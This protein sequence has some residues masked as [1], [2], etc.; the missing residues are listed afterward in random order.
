MK[1]R[2]VGAELFHADRRTGHNEDNS[3]FFAILRKRINNERIPT[4]SR[5]KHVRQTQGQS[6]LWFLFHGWTARSGPRPLVSY[7]SLTLGHTTVG[8]T[9]LDEWPARRRDHYLTTNTTQN[10]QTSMS[11]AGFEPTT[12]SNQRPSGLTY[13]LLVYLNCL[14]WP[15][16]CQNTVTKL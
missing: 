5:H 7:S 6:I 13:I 16:N 11:S 15:W 14:W 8:R 1:I 12:P 3:R 4:Y 10:T 9:P 2:R